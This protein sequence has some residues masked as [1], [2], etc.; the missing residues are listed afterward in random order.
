MLSLRESVNRSSQAKTSSF[1]WS[2]TIATFQIFDLSGAFSWQSILIKQ[3]DFY[4]NL[5]VLFIFFFF[6]QSPIKEKEN[7]TKRKRKNG[8]ALFLVTSGVLNSTSLLSNNSL[9]LKQVFRNNVSLSTRCE[10][11]SGLL[12]RCTPRNDEL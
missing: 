7:V 2:Y 4:K 11:F 6:S 10:S 9:T 8:S 3:F 1:C 5:K 12:R